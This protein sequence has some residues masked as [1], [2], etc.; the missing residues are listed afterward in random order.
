MNNL[1]KKLNFNGVPIPAFIFW[2]ASFL[3][4]IRMLVGTIPFRSYFKGVGAGFNF[5]T[6]MTF[7]ALAGIG[8]CIFLKLRIGVAGGVALIALMEFINLVASWI[9]IG[10]YRGSFF[11]FSGSMSGFVMS[12]YW[13][14]RLMAMLCLAAVIIL[15]CFLPKSK[16]IINKLFFI[17]AAVFAFSALLGIGGFGRVSVG[18]LMF[19]EALAIAAAMF[20][21]CMWLKKEE[22]GFASAGSA[23]RS[24]ANR[25]ASRAAAPQKEVVEAEAKVIINCENCGQPLKVPAGKHLQVTCPKCGHTFVI[26]S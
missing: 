7:L 2:G 3:M 26:N 11:G 25:N 14:F 1:L 15:P 24:S 13:W 9:Y 21:I 4:F 20:F 23:N 10:R 22:P 8:V 16:N 19:L 5:M 12:M 6:V 18:I 17:P